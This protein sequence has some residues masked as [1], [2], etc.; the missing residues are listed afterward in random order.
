M[1]RLS[2]HV[3]ILSLLGL[4]LFVPASRAWAQ[5]ALATVSGTIV[6]PD[7]DLIPGATITLTPAAGKATILTSGS[8]GSYSVKVAPGTYSMTV[9][10]QGFSAF[11]RL[12]MKLTPGQVLPVNAKMTLEDQKQ[13]VLVTATANSV[14]VDQDSNASSTVIKGDALDA[15]SDDPDELSSELSALA[16]PAAGPNGGQIYIDGFTGGQLPPKSSIREIRINQNP[17]SAQYDRL[18]Y[19]RV[20]IF[21]KPGTDKFHGSAQLNGY[22]SSFNSGSPLLG[23]SAIQ[24]YHTIFFLGN[25]T[26]PLSKWASFSVAGSYR[27]IQD[28]VVVNP[29]A[30]YSLASS[31]GTYCFPATAG[32]IQ[33]TGFTQAVLT[34]QTRWDISPRID[35]ALGEKN[36][37][38]ARFQYTTNNQKNQGMGGND[39]TSTGY[40]TDSSEA[41][42]QISDTQILSANIINETR[43]EYQRSPTQ[44]TPYSTVSTINVQGAF[45]GGGVSSGSQR[46]V[47]QH[48]EVQNYTSIALKKHFIRFGGRLRTTGENNT[49]TSGQNGTFTYNSIGNYAT[50]TIGQYTVT[51]ITNPTINFR[52]TD[53]G[54]YAEDDWKIRPNFTLSAGIR[55]ETQ[56]YIHDQADFA[57]RISIAYGVGHSKTAPKTVLRGGFGIF[58]DRFQSGSQANAIRNNGVNQNPFVVDATQISTGC[59]PANPAACTVAANAQSTTYVIAN[60]LRSPYTMQTAIGVDQQLFKGATVSVTYLNGRGVHQYVSQNQSYILNGPST[61]APIQYQYQ[62]EGA[63]RQNQLVTNVNYRGPHNTSLFGFYMLNFAKSNTN[64]ITSFPTNPGN[65]GLDYGRASYDVRNRLFLGGSWTAPHGINISP[66]LV[67]NAGSPYNLTTGA[68]N[69]GD[70]IYNERV[71]FATAGTTGSKS[72]AGCGTFAAPAVGQ[73][74][75][76]VPINYCTGPANF[77]MN[78][79]VTKT[80]GFGARIGQP[81][82]KRGQ[83][84]AQGGPQGPM[85]GGGH[86]GHGGG[87][88]GGGPGGGMGGASTGRRYNLILGAQGSNIFNVVDRGAPVG[89]FTSPSFGQSTQ[90]AGN[91]FTSNSAIRRVLLQASFTF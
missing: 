32:C 7:N 64:G 60:N 29:N 79:R 59:S 15:L 82:G 4:L 13:E 71:A 80:F 8:D 19:G 27:D 25:M 40:T 38:T 45:T 43:F 58:Y 53:L 78:L 34:P 77:T 18:G 49:S 37:L 5:Q 62:S 61:T 24:P 41:T 86:G 65:I 54:L 81:A 74:Y 91:I 11:V 72:I 48:I 88:G 69:N 30:I 68:D 23:K 57:P 12:S 52:T 46:V 17:F 47:D 85:G 6:D 16:G 39:L 90:L 26:G 21:T 10:M 3:L 66:F 84:Q 2:K 33:N 51:R 73:S 76:E 75:T 70:S 9:T 35:L 22:D 56:N 63:F 36:T 20:E 83:Q 44:Q 14:S 50:N 89:T 42:I 1:S 67:A 87:P 28:N 31:P 55:Y